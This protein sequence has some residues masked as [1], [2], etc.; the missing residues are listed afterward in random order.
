MD[1]AA[2]AALRVAGGLEIVTPAW[3]RLARPLARALSAARV[4]LRQVDA[5]VPAALRVAGGLEIV[6][7]A[8]AR[9]ARPSAHEPRPLFLGNQECP[10]YS[11]M[12][13]PRFMKNSATANNTTAE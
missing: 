6:T 8:W 3:A 4:T 9:L 1:A 2:S 12:P 7:P 5:A 10:H 13:V 11:R